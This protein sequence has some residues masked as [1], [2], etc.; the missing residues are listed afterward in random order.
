[1]VVRS[2]ARMPWGRP[3]VRVRGMMVV[4][5]MRAVITLTGALGT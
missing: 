3:R 1:M 4:P 5:V 2:C